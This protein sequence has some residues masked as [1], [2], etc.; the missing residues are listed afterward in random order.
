MCGLNKNMVQ[1]AWHLYTYVCIY[2]NYSILISLRFIVLLLKYYHFAYFWCFK[3]S[4]GFNL[5]LIVVLTL[6]I[7]EIKISNT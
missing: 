5:A 6:Q 1:V 3:A 2:K 4:E 7:T